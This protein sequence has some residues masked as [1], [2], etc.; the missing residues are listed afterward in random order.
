MA[1]SDSE[2][3]ESDPDSEHSTSRSKVYGLYGQV[4][5]PDESLSIVLFKTLRK[6][7]HAQWADKVSVGAIALM[8]NRR[9]P[10][11][12]LGFGKVPEE[13][14]VC[15]FLLNTGWIAFTVPEG[16]DADGNYIVKQSK[17][18]NL[19]PS[20]ET[21]DFGD[22]DLLSLLGTAFADHKVLL[23]TGLSS[24]FQERGDQSSSDSGVSD[25]EVHLSPSSPTP[26]LSPSVSFVFPLSR[27]LTY[28][29]LMQVAPVPAV[30]RQISVKMGGEP[31]PLQAQKR[32]RRRAPADVEFPD[33]YD[34]KA[35]AA[36][37]AAVA[38]AATIKAQQ[39]AIDAAADRAARKAY[40]LAVAAN[41]KQEKAKAAAQ[42]AAQ[43]VPPAAVIASPVPVPVPAA[44]PG[45]LPPGYQPPPNAPTGVFT[46]CHIICVDALMVCRSA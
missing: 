16:G 33:P 23:T 24:W 6:P 2:P 45:S 27:Y 9:V 21:I 3:E 7:A 39:A 43:V 38:K 10:V 11:I 34:D 31:V 22:A 28:A 12:I 20:G 32:R 41:L 5:T 46:L 15:E 40:E 25:G 18:A 14:R 8:G 35:V 4:S 1:D 42:A 26:S 13:L 37:D 19:I 36:I 44:T 17:L 29:R 30:K